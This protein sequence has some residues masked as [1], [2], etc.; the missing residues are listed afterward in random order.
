M[1]NHAKFLFRSVFLQKGKSLLQYGLKTSGHASIQHRYMNAPPPAPLL[2]LRKDKSRNLPEQSNHGTSVQ[3]H[4]YICITLLYIGYTYK[5][6]Q[7]W[8][9]CQ[10]IL[11]ITTK[12][13]IY[14]PGLEHLTCLL[15]TCN[16]RVCVYVM[17]SARFI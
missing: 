7:F 11:D 2:G 9:Y 1:H 8:Y 16:V 6:G 12:F 3:N 5:E 15:Q 17:K 13:H 10:E 4:G 14:L